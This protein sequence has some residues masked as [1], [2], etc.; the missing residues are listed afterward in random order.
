MS[1]CR[2]RDEV[3]P[4]TA[5][6]LARVRA[7]AT[8]LRDAGPLLVAFSGGVDSSYLA[9]AAVDALGAA[10][11]LGVTG[12]S[13]SYPAAQWVAARTVAE[14]IGLTVVELDTLELDDPAYRANPVDRCYHCKAELWRRLVPIAQRRG[15]TLVDGTNAD[16]RSDYRPGARAGLE[17]GV[18]SPLAEV[19]LT[20][21]EIRTLS[22]ARG[23]PTWRQPSAPCLA[24]RL[25]YGFEVTAERLAAVERAEAALRALGLAGDLRVRHHGELARIELAPHELDVWLVPGRVEQLCA[26]VRAAGFA[27]VAVDLRGFRSGSLNV[28]G[29]VVA[30]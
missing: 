7:L 25:P 24:S 22:R 29:G 20:K 15:M 16:D 3:D 6:T 8:L 1:E 12:R 30:A 2:S 5:A 11:V 27:R 23:L 14:A 28:L 10:R 21:A 26:A 9:A 19:G 4:P 18:R 17:A 13:A